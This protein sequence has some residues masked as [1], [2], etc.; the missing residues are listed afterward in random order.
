MKTNYLLPAFISILIL[1]AVDAY[2]QYNKPSRNLKQENADLSITATELYRQ[3]SENVTEANGQYLD[4]V[5]LVRGR[6]QSINRGE[7]GSLNLI[8]DAGSEMGGIICEFPKGN[9]PPGMNLQT[10]K[11]LTIKGQCT[12][13]L[14]D[15]VLV[16]C[17]IVN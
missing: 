8:L 11:E 7:A 1:V 14:M 2:W 16:K 12:G 6:L 10:G 17:V 13:F 9:L 4:K 5:L 15:V 3:C